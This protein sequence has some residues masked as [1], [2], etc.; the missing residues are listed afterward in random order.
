M[1]VFK[2]ILI[3]ILVII[4]LVVGGAYF[5]I[6]ST[7]PEYSGKVHLSGL[8]SQAKIIYDHYGVPHIYAENAHDAYYAFGYAH[9]QDRLFQMV[10]MR[11]VMSGRLSEILGKDLI[12]TDK[13]MRTLSIDKMAQ[14]NADIFMKNADL[15][16]KN[17]VQAY[18]DGINSFIERG[19]LPIEFTLIGFKPE[20]FTVKD[21]FGIIGYM[22]LTFTSAL[23]EIPLVEKI[24]DKLGP[25]YLKDLGIDSLSY[26]K[27]YSHPK[28][29]LFASILSQLRSAQNMIPIPVWEGSNNWVLAGTRSKSGK[30]LLGN[31]THIKYSQPAVWYESYMEYPGYDMYGYYLAG[32]PYALVG[33]NGQFGWGLTIFPFSNMFLYAEKKNPQNP[34]QYW[35]KNGWKNDS[36][37]HQIIKVKG[38]KAVPFDIHYTD[39]GPIINPVYENFT[40][41]KDLPIALWWAPMHIKSTALEALYEI[42]HATDMNTFEKGMSK[43]DVVGLNVVYGDNSGNIAWWATGKIPQ[44]PSNVNPRFLLDGASG[45]EDVLGFYPFD[46]NPKSIN[47][48]SGYI[49]TSNNEPPPVDGITYPG[50]Y[51]PGYRARRVKQLILSQPKWTVNEMKRIQLDVFSQRDLNMSQLI[52]KNSGKHD[53]NS[54]FVQALNNWDGE[55]HRSSTGAVIYTQMLYFIFRDAMEDEVGSKT[56]NKL[57]S[58]MLLKGNIETLFTDSTSVWW[59]NVNTKKVETRSDIFNRAFAETERAL[60]NQLGDTVQKWKWGH[61]HQLL[62][63][64][65]I[66]RKPPF[67]HYF[68]VGPFPISGSNGVV[69]KEA[70][71]YNKNGVYPVTSGPALRFLIDFANTHKAISVIPTGQSGNVLSPHYADQAKLFVN[72]KYRP[73]IT[74]KS[75][76]KKGKVL[77]L[78]PETK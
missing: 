29:S 9:A 74:L 61:V 14:Q 77:T 75:E 8:K 47:P 31:D 45:K 36:V 72:G 4:V 24:Y 44:L 28:D 64:S 1:K 54:T 27:F 15:P 34:N 7:A 65:P 49:N 37:D 53:F 50:Y 38:A 18:V 67:D 57:C 73:Q 78:V 3:V 60:K 66:G 35:Y 26:A 48:A 16:I 25:D 63:M 5:W 46:K 56:F 21:V 59:D 23:S 69:D 42:N 10:M 12:K 71:A 39:H 70:F 17:Q 52:L 33:H 22:S 30:P 55:Y 19:K 32:V 6:R 2:T 62:N 43:I 13:Y 40:G 20:K 76:L 68:N 41:K 51:F 11:R 58:S